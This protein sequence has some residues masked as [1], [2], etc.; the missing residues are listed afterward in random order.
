[1]AA[2]TCIDL[3]RSISAMEPRFD[4]IPTVTKKR[5]PANPSTALRQLGPPAPPG[6]ET[7]DLTADDY[8]PNRRRRQPSKPCSAA[9][10]TS[11]EPNFSAAASRSTT[12]MCCG[13]IPLL[14]FLVAI[15]LTSFPPPKFT[16]V[17]ISIW[18]RVSH[19]VSQPQAKDGYGW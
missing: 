16:Q 2:S 14:F 4:R 5:L 3:K 11:S 9:I 7:D 18:K 13:P 1:M 8:Q 19:K 12:M 15:Y 17:Q 10:A 6:G